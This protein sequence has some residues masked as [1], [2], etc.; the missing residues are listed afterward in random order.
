[1][2]K[3][4]I[5]I[6]YWEGSSSE[7]LSKTLNSLKNELSLINKLI[8]V[9]D[10]ENSFFKIKIEDKAIENKLLLIYL[11]DNQGPGTARN[12]GAIFS[13]A[14]NLLFLD[15]GDMNI[16]NRILTQNKALNNDYVSVGAI[17]EVNS[18]GISRI[19]F[20]SKNLLIAKSFLPYKNPFNNVSIGIKREF[21]ISIGGYGDTRVGEDWIL[22]GKVLT[23]TKK[24]NITDKVFVLVNVKENFLQRR[25]GLKIYSEIKKSLEKL[26]SLN[27]IN[28]QEL[29]ISKT[30]QKISRVYLSKYILSFIYKLNR[31]K[32]KF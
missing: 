13:D 26:Y 30:I 1:M 14:E 8:I 29:L 31:T 10:G 24:I 7:D 20:S 6:P 17:K 21:F 28:L 16:H 22:S 18:I 27:I 3:T 2:I 19:K 12:V 9:F 15:T 11:I 32:A 4:D 5:I 23:R 25:S